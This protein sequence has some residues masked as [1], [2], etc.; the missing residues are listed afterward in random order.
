MHDAPRDPLAEMLAQRRFAAQMSN[1]RVRA[2]WILLALI[3]AYTGASLFWGGLD[4]GSPRFTL[5]LMKMGAIYGPAVAEG[6]RWRLLAGTLLHGGLLHLAMNLYALVVL[7]RFVE[8]IVGGGRL[9]VIYTLSALGGALG[10]AWFGEGLSVGASGAIWG[11]M[12][13]T[14]ALILRPGGLIP[15]QIA[16]AIGRRLLPLLVLNVG[17]SFLPRV[18]L[19]AHFLGGAVGLLV[20]LAGPLRPRPGGPRGSAFTLAA[21]I[22]AFGALAASGALAVQRG[23]PWQLSGPPALEDAAI[24]D[25]GITLPLPV[26]IGPPEV[27]VDSPEIKSLTFGALI[28]PDRPVPRG[29]CVYDVKVQ[30]LTAHKAQHRQIFQETVASL[31]RNLK[32]SG[33]RLLNER[34]DLDGPQPYYTVGL[35]LGGVASQIFMALLDDQIIRVEVGWLAGDEGMLAALDALARRLAPR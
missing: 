35:D 26:G 13:A 25:T 16:K 28:D 29:R 2:T 31:A 1:P 23:A 15:P 8:P 22:L 34:R 27:K 30:R 18:D 9:T 11:L 14:G 20:T 3:L 24:S 12:G 17:I 4:E 21:G 6:E 10:S 7:G 33:P 32:E 5:T 19:Y